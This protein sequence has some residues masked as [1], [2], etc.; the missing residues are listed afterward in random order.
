MSSSLCQYKDIFGKPKTGAHRY[1]VFD[2]AI[3][4]VVMT[5]VAA[6]IIARF[7]KKCFWKT[8][9]ILFILGILLH[10]LFCVNTTVGVFLWGKL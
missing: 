5:I 2:L 6:Y 7:F 1:R 8:L 10:Y 3:V 9:I 4:D